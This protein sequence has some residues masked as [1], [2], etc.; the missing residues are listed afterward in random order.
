MEVATTYNAA[1]RLE[2]ILDEIDSAAKLA[3][4]SRADIDLIA[5]SKTRSAAAIIPLL[6]AG[7]RVFGR[8]F[9][10]GSG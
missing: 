9:Y 3:R 5:V 10:R 8:P 4:R 2:Q 1:E 6:E 7:H